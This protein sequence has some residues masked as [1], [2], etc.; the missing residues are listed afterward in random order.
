MCRSRMDLFRLREVGT[1]KLVYE[2][3]QDISF[4]RGSH[5]VQDGAHGGLG[6][7]SFHFPQLPDQPPFYDLSAVDGATLKAFLYNYE[8]SLRT[9][10]ALLRKQLPNKPTLQI[11]VSLTFS[12][13]LRYIT[14]GALIHSFLCD[15]GLSLE[16]YYPFDGEWISTEGPSAPCKFSIEADFF[17]CDGDGYKVSVSEDRSTAFLIH[18]SRV[19]REWKILLDLSCRGP[20]PG[21]SITWVNIEDDSQIWVWTRETVVN[22]PPSDKLI[23]LGSRNGVVYRRMVGVTRQRQ[24]PT[25]NRDGLWGNVFC[26]AMKVGLASYHFVSPTESYLSYEHPT[27]SAWPSLDN[28]S[29]I[30]SRVYFRNVSF[31][32]YIFKAQILWNEDFQTSWSGMSRWDYTI[33]FDPNFMVIRGGKVDGC[34]TEGVSREMS[35]YGEDLLYVNAG[36]W[37]VMHTNPELLPGEGN[38]HPSDSLVDCSFPLRTVLD[39]LF[40][41]RE[42]PE[43]PIDYNF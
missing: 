24:V 3:N 7:G 10:R 35:R 6:K 19:K 27:S 42:L 11:L 26:Q 29:P 1:E 9:F 40:T 16:F 34:T 18:A 25:Y 30:P 33:V 38:V 20:C 22:K 15:K 32:N 21:D 28:G 14:A 41:R 39:S 17:R 31:N 13:D 23:P 8:H 37:E 12:D 43:S 2:A 36:L 5:Y 4:L